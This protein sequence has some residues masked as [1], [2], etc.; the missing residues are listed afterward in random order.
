MWHIYENADWASHD[1]CTFIILN[2]LHALKAK[3]NFLPLSFI[4][5]K[6]LIFKVRHSLSHTN[7]NKTISIDFTFTLKKWHSDDWIMQFD[8]HMTLFC[9]SMYLNEWDSFFIT[10]ILFRFLFCFGR[11][12]ILAKAI[13]IHH[14]VIDSDMLLSVRKLRFCTMLAFIHINIYAAN[15]TK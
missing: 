8:L 1:N 15:W 14:I 9:V 12:I 7:R 2:N 3:K 5:I 11:K 4:S 13:L 6:C 10:A